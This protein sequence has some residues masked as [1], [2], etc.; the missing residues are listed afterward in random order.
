MVLKYNKEP[1]SEENM[2]KKKEKQNQTKTLHQN[3]YGL[4]EATTDTQ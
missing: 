1:C 4:Q 2:K 3:K